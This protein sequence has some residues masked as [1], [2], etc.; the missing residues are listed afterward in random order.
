MRSL[1]ICIRRIFNNLIKQN[2]K[3]GYSR[4]ESARPQSS[5]QGPES[6]VQGSESFVESPASRLQLPES[7]VQS[8]TSRVQRLTLASRVQEFRYARIFYS[9]CQNWNSYKTFRWTSSECLMYVRFTPCAQRTD[10]LPM[11]LKSFCV[12]DHLGKN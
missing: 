5:V 4:E 7:S 6:I 12:V 1:E 3:L 2:Q 8:L 9:R 11:L 10:N